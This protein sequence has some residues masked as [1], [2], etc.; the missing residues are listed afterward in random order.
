[1][2]ET[3]TETA[4]L[5][6]NIVPKTGGNRLEGAA[7]FSGTGENLQS[8]NFTPEL[9][10]AGLAQ[11]TPISKVYDLNG[12]VGGPIAKDRVWYFVNARTQGSTRVTANQFYNLNVG[13]PTK[14]LYAPDTTRPGFSDRTWENY[15]PRITWQINGRNQLTGSWH[16]QPVC[17]NCEGTRPGWR[18]RADCRARSGWTERHDPCA[19]NGVPRSRTIPAGAV[20]GRRNTDGELRARGHQ[21]A[22]ARPHVG[23]VCGRMRNNGGIAGLVYGSQD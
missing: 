17:R 20:S 15:T 12:A 4:G 9:K 22:R 2:S 11:A 10:A 13:D 14:W 7:F 18:R 5:V 6:M 16:E 19:Y 23:A 1:M 8:D 3:L 21:H